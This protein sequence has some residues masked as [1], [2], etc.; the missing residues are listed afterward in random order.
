VFHR[1]SS[2][3]KCWRIPDN[4]SARTDIVI[5]TECCGL[6][7][8]FPR[9]RIG[10]SFFLPWDDW[11]VGRELAVTPADLVVL[12]AGSRG[13]RTAVHRG[14][15]DPAREQRRARRRAFHPRMQARPCFAIL[16]PTADFS[17][18]TSAR[19][20]STSAVVTS[21]IGADARSRLR[22]RRTPAACF[23]F[24]TMGIASWMAI[25]EVR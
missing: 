8:A 9:S 19:N 11:R 23:V 13:S 25:W 3:E 15:E 12:E 21:L 22:V 17:F 2:S 18:A 16:A 20:R 10:F 6:D 24:A 5:V 7:S 1:A 14:G 4:R